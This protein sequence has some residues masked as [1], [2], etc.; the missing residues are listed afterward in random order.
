MKKTQKLILISIY[1]ALSIALDITKEFMPFLNMPS[2]GSVNIA[3]IPIALSSFHLG[4]RSG[5]LVGLLWFTIS[6]LIGL[7]KYFVSFGQIIFDY[8]IPSIILGASA[9]FYKKRKFIEVEMGILLMMIIRTFSIVLSGAVYWFDSS[10]A[11]GSY[12]AWIGSIVYNLP[13]S[14]ATLVMLM[15]VIPL[16]LNSLKKYLYNK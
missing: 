3:L 15:I 5:I 1:V 9:I 4:N 12:E 11:S 7:N 2:G 16:L 14:L 8:I 13:Y 10:T 6:S